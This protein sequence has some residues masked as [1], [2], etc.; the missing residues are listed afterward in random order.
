MDGRMG[1]VRRHGGES[2]DDAYDDH[3]CTTLCTTGFPK[4]PPNQNFYQATMDP[5]SSICSIHTH[6]YTCHTH[7]SAG[8]Q[9]VVARTKWRHRTPRTNALLSGAAE[10]AEC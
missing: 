1:H 4:F 10:W 5:G 9:H 3:C 2:G 7:P 6:T 8:A